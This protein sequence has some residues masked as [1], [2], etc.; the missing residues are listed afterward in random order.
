MLL[1]HPFDDDESLLCTLESSVSAGEA[2]AGAADIADQLRAGGIE[3]GQAVA[4]QLPNDPSA[5]V[6]M[7]G[8]W[9]AGAVYVPLNPRQT[10]AEVVAAMDA[11]APAA[12]LDGGGVRA[13]SR[14]DR[15]YDPD[16]AFVTWTSGT[17]GLPKPV[18]QTHSG[19]FE[20]L[21]RV[22]GTI[23]TDPSKRPPPNLIP[24]PLALNAGIYNV[25]F[26]LRAGAA[27]VIMERFATADFA[28]LVRRFEIRSTVL[29]PAGMTMLADDPAVTDLAPLRYVRSITAPLSPL[30]ARR[31]H[32]KF[33][34]T[35]LNGYGQAEI[36]EVIGWTAA[37]A[38]EHPEKLGA[39]G[40]PHP[41]VDIELTEEGEL[42]V[43]PPRTAAGLDAE[44]V[45]ADG[46]VHTGDLARVDDD[47]FVWIEGRISDVINR[48]GN[49]VFPDH[50]EEVLR[51]SP[52]VLDVAVVGVADER[53]GE[54][55]VAFVV[56]EADAAA[57]DALCREH[58]V[59]YKV[60]AEFRFV[61][62]LPRN[63]VGKVLRRELIAS[64]P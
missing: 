33:G 16:T 13:L 53:L 6:A 8:A 23:R 31:F 44:R 55:P 19:Y 62:S 54:V 5:V 35:V 37:D 57:L 32:D 26:G 52:S 2:R 28:E 49:K 3:P 38:R 43:R 14:S 56:G 9:L 27:V 51:L 36:G 22:L 34:V 25:L 21:D 15:R 48:G 20:I 12:F 41:G 24:V 10:N 59:P 63:D 42:L 39:V 1:D 58:L 29:P 30:A 50:V 45:D 4:V 60:P 18:L 7:F 47:G 40:R 64:Y 61:E 46:F 11:A 17:T